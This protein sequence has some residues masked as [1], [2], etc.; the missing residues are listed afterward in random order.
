MLIPPTTLTTV[1][2]VRPRGVLHIGAHDGEEDLQYRRAGWGDVVWVEAMPDKA[3][4]LEARFK[5]DPTR[6]VVTALAW[7][8]SG[9]EMVFHLANN[10][11]SSSVFEFGT[12]ADHHPEISFEADIR[13]RSVRLDAVRGL[14][15]AWDLINLDVQGAE[16]H[17]LRGLGTLILNARWIYTE[18][19]QENVYAGCP[20]MADLDAWLNPRGFRRIDTVMT[21]FGWGD[22]LYARAEVIPAARHIRRAAR[23][24]LTVKSQLT[25]SR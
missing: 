25:D 12:H 15:L 13:L 7:D 6:Q 16:L 9:E 4:A 10:G 24:F 1:W 19:N 5:N 23:R 11:M 17:A 21:Q 3:R 2:N 20:L 18:V 22:A 14:P 8:S